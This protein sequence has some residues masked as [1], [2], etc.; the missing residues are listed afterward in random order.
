MR[1]RS[2]VFFATHFIDD[3]L[4]KLNCLVIFV[5]FQDLPN[6]RHFKCLLHTH[7]VSVCSDIDKSLL[8][9]LTIRVSVASDI[10]R[11]KKRS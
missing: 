7:L 6:A 11:Q 1:G 2:V 5:N 8:V 9:V 4:H 10:T 3:Y